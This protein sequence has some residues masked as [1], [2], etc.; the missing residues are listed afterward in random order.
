MGVASCGSGAARLIDGQRQAVEGAISGALIPVRQ[1]GTQRQF[2]AQYRSEGAQDRRE[3]QQRR[4]AP[5]ETD[6]SQRREDAE[7]DDPQTEPD[8]HLHGYRA[9][10]RVG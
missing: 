10:R 4:K 3:P 1:R 9:V 8:K 7:D 5:A 6:T 2:S